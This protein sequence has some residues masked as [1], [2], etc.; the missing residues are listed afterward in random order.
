MEKIEKIYR[1]IKETEDE[2]EKNILINYFV[3]K[4]K[5]LTESSESE[6]Y[7]EISSSYKKVDPILEM[8]K[9]EKFEKFKEIIKKIKIDWSNY[10]GKKETPLH[11]A[12]E[13]G[14]TRIFKVLLERNYP[15]WLPNKKNISPLELSCLRN[16]SLM[17]RTC[18]QY[19]ANLKKIIYFR[20]NNRNIFYNNKNFDFIIFAKKILIDSKYQENFR[21]EDNPKLIGLGNYTWEDFHDSLGILI[22]DKNPDLFSWY[23]EVFNNSKIKYN[24]NEWLKFWFILNLPFNVSEYD[25][26]YIELDY[27]R[28]YMIN[29]KIKDIKL[30]IEYKFKNDYKNIYSKEFLEL[31]LKLWSNRTK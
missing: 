22:K 5:T 9:K 24:E 31:V 3:R 1:K 16:D 20:E 21:N 28:D 25:F 12:I 11:I 15:I 10:I 19:N 17:I 8:I 23:L 4:F 14:D 13:N 7:D 30:K 29:K 2:D 27:L 18:L 6:K 26:F